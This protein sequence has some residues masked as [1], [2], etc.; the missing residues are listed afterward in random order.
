MFK[1][2]LNKGYS[3]EKFLGEFTVRDKAITKAKS[4]TGKGIV[5]VIESNKGELYQIYQNLG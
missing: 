1:V 3:T 4:Q 2:Y 5:E